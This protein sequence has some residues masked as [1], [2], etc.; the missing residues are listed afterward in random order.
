MTIYEIQYP[1]GMEQFFHVGELPTRSK[2]YA[3]CRRISKKLGKCLAKFKLFDQKIEHG[4][5][6]C[7][8]HY[9]DGKRTKKE[10]KK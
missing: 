8:V 7:W 2:V 5:A 6:E 10:I 4:H 1:G 3:K 9:K